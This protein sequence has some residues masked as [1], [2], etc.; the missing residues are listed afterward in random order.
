MHLRALPMIAL[1]LAAAALPAGTAQDG[2]YKVVKTV[3]QRNNLPRIITCV[4][5]KLVKTSIMTLCILFFI[6]GPRS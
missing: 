3:K 2:P 6:F 1:G 5:I 4:I